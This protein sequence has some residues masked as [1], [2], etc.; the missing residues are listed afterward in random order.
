[1]NKRAVIVLS[2]VAA[3][4]VAYVVVF[5]RESLTSKEVAEREDKVLPTFVRAKVDRLEVQ[6]KGHTVV[7]EREQKAEEEFGGW[8]MLEPTREAADDDTVD[9][10][11]GELEWLAARRT[12][13]SLSAADVKAFGLDKPRY[14]VR[15]RAGGASHTLL[16]GN[17]DV[18][19]EGVYVRVDQEPGGFVVP[20]TLV[21]TL[22]HDPLHYRSK[23]F[24]GQMTTAWAR[25]L[26]II[27]PT[28]PEAA[29]ATVEVLKEDGR[30]WVSGAP[31]VLADAPGVEKVLR[32][33]DDLRAARFLEPSAAPAAQADLQKPARIVKLSIVPDEHREDR[34]PML[35]ELQL[36][37]ACAGHEGERYARAGD[38]GAP[39]CI[40]ADDAKPFETDAAHLRLP[41]VFAAEPSSIERFELVQGAQKLSLKREGEGWKAEGNPAVDREAV[42]QWLADLGRERAL[43]FLAPAAFKEQASLTLHLADDKTE[44]IGV[45]AAP[46]GDVWLKRGDEPALA[47]FPRALGDLFVPAPKRFQALDPWASQQPSEVTGLEARDE[48]ATRTMTLTEGSW[49]AS[50]TAPV[51]SNQVRE[52]VRALLK[53]RA[54]SYVTEQPRPEHGLASPRAALQLK[55]AKA[56]LRLD[57]GA[58]TERGAY[59]RL[60]GG[61]VF[62]VDR[63]TVQRVQALAGT[64]GAP[65]PPPPPEEEHEEGEH[66]EHSD[67]HEH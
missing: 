5:E 22:D 6:R 63:D 17:Q 20:K 46:N 13:E 4:L 32:T 35:V 16:I 51:D 66:E 42:E 57:I 65:M 59:A 48:K 21:E 7:L 47:V 12:L 60:D 34:Q 52:L 37:G 33:L 54:L 29:G 26:E 67:E 2:L 10:L 58:E 64:R 24:L 31:K 56:T 43:T 38:K 15:Y 25:K 28:T 39:V 8:L 23:E 40:K 36:G 49:K 30:F 19:G 27:T 44:R 53:L 9:H 50:G 11:L 18:H 14:R 45:G 1:M 61:A 3:A 62:E 55:L 41:R